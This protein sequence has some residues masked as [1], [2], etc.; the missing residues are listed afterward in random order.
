MGM[1]S[2][3]FL[4]VV[5]TFAF[6][7]LSCLWAQEQTLTLDIFVTNPSDEEVQEVEVKVDLPEE[8]KKEDIIS[9]DGLKVGYD[10]EKDN[11]YVRGSV[12]LQPAETTI[13]KIEVRD[14]WVIPENEVRKLKEE[15]SKYQSVRVSELPDTLIP[16]TLILKLDRILARQRESA[17]DISA[18]IA[19]YRENK[20]ELSAVRSALDALRQEQERAT[21]DAQ[22]KDAQKAIWLAVWTAI[23][24]TVAFIGRRRLA[25]WVKRVVSKYQSV[26]VSKNEKAENKGEK[27]IEE[28]KETDEQDEEVSK[29][30]SVR[31]SELPRINLKEVKIES[32]VIEKIPAKFVWHYKFMPV[33][34]EEDI[35]TVACASPDNVLRDDLRQFLGFKIKMVKASDEDILEAIK[36]FYGVGAETVEKILDETVDSGEWLVDSEGKEEDIARLAEEPGVIKLVNQILLEAH[37]KNATDIHIEPCPGKLKLRY[38]IDGVLYDAKVPAN[39]VRFLPAIISRVKI[40]SGLDIVERRLPQDGR[41][42][43]KIKN[44]L[45]D[46]RISTMPTPCGESIVIRILPTTM[47]FSLEKL[48]FLERDLRTFEELIKKPHGIIFVT[49]PTGSGKTTTLYTALS[50]IKEEN[51]GAKILTIEDPIEYELEGITQTQVNPEIG[52]NFARGLRSML[53]HDPDIMMVGEVRDFETAE[54][55]IRMALTGHLLFSTLH[56]NDAASGVAR[57]LDIGVEPYLI[58]SSVEA[59]IAQRLVRMV[60]PRCR[61]KGCEICNSTGY[62]GRTAIFELLLVNEEIKKLITQKATAD[63]IKKKAVSQGMKTLWEDGQEK[64]KK[65]ITT[66][67]EVLRVTQ[68]R[69]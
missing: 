59:F 69:E 17:G 28:I 13:Y 49:G 38:R 45:F 32:D 62:R 29:Y 25:V 20:K 51:K 43:V 52:L 37:Q 42:K 34:L 10:A 44:E 21:Q 57:L 30:Q 26:K 3:K 16:D 1:K 24:G 64:I 9:S 8:L 5:F 6:L 67:E 36:K 12:T 4:I 53:R 66:R 46:L 61:G 2:F 14:V 58:A 7:V 19:S 11:C 18:H 50:K 47:L 41:A 39:I 15:V 60:C 54:I 65:G 48:G 33:R 27:I 68:E 40:M 63:E 56:T 35:L 31:V 23:L 55:A 22:R